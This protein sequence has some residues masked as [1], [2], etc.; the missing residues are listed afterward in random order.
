MISFFGAISDCR[1]ILDKIANVPR[2]VL[3]EHVLDLISSLSGI[4]LKL[5][6]DAQKL[7]NRSA[8]VRMA[9]E[10]NNLIIHL[11]TALMTWFEIKDSQ[12]PLLVLAM[13]ELTMLFLQ[14]GG[15]AIS[16]DAIGLFLSQPKSLVFI[17][18]LSKHTDVEILLRKCVDTNLIRFHDLEIGL[19]QVLD[20]CNLTSFEAEICMRLLDY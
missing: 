10:I 8:E 5:R 11:K 3:T 4:T 1:L 15:P 13:M 6:D 2:P 7:D 19:N 17:L 18:Q 14:I 16:R 20:D 9:I 12:A